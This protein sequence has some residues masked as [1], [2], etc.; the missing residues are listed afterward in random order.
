MHELLDIQIANYIYIYIVF[1][2]FDHPHYNAMILFLQ[3]FIFHYVLFFLLTMFYLPP[4]L[5][6][7]YFHV[8]KL[9]DDIQGNIYIYT[10]IRVLTRLS[11]VSTLYT[12]V[13]CQVRVMV[14]IFRYRY[15]CSEN[16]CEFRFFII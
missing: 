9:V 10:V 15:V 1:P 5:T 12:V 14:N 16:S 4:S 8:P 3:K 6:P 11:C 2:L 7:Q 13:D